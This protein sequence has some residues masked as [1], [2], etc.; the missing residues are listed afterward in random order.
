[1]L[2]NLSQTVEYSKAGDFC[3]T[4]TL[5]FTGPT[6]Q[7][8]D[9]SS[10]ISQL[11]M[12]AVLDAKDLADKFS[13]NNEKS[14][15]DSMNA[16]AIKIILLSSKSVKFSELAE[17]CKK[18]FEKVGTFDGEVNLKASVMDK[19]SINDFTKIICE[20]I[21]NFIFPSLFSTEGE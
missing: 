1:M 17:L 3:K 2:F 21:S 7:V 13:S 20:Y 4:A 19:L 14:A 11:V 18:L 5:E 6:M 10:E 12:R 16:E 15:S 9:L 8:F